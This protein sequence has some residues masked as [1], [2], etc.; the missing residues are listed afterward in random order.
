MGP[1]LAG[2]FTGAPTEA[3]RPLQMYLVRPLPPI[4]GRR[5]CCS[6]NLSS[7]D[8]ERPA[9]PALPAFPP[10]RL[11]AFPPLPAILI[12]APETRQ[13]PPKIGNLFVGHN[14]GLPEYVHTT[15]FLF[16]PTVDRARR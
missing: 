14:H 9:L 3:A 6:L 5:Q 11:R 7:S 12:L 1:P 8:G 16:L 13:P 2:M 15:G 10:S 4:K